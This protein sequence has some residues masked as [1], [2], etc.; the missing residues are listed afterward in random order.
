MQSLTNWIMRKYLPQTIDANDQAVRSRVGVLEAWVSIVS[1]IGLSLLKLALGLR[2]NSISLL[3]DALHSASDVVTSIV[4]LFGFRAARMPADKE[5]PYGHGRVEPIATLIIAILL[6]LVA[7]EVGNSSVKRFMSA[8]VVTGSYAV[9]LIIAASAV[10]KEWM[11]RFSQHLGKIV[12]SSTLVA[13]AWHHR[14]DAITSVMV[15]IAMVASRLG[16][17][18]VDAI[19]G[20]VM[21]IIILAVGWELGRSAASTLI[22]QGASSAVIEQINQVA[23]SVPGVYDVHQVAVHDY[24]AG[25]G[26]VSLHIRVDE[27]LP[28]RESHG[29]A[30]DVESRLQAGLG[31]AAT[32]HVEPLAE[33]ER[34][35]S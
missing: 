28:V 18:K 13:D 35:T 22:G 31:F 27:D 25:Q 4:V 5:H 7:L 24:G 29:I 20:V 16:Y 12:G 8:E 3:A 10:F 21:S 1:N 6:A 17:P 9:A 11:A 32:V 14:S 30:E 19:F 26:R 15:A 2:L 23:A 34:E 33:A